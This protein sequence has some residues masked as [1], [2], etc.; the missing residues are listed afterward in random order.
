MKLLLVLETDWVSRGPAQH[1]H[2]L[3][4][5]QDRGH[6]VKVIDFDILWPAK[7]WKWPWAKR[8]RIFA[9][10]KAIG[11]NPMEVIRPSMIRAPLLCYASFIPSFIVETIRQIRLFKPDV[12]LGQGVL[13]VFL[14]TRIAK[15]F[16]IPFVRYLLDSGHTLIPESY[17]RPLGSW[18]ETQGLKQSDEVLV[19]NEQLGEYAT[20]M[21]ATTAPK[22]VTAGIDQSRFNRG[23]DGMM[24]R[25]RL[26]FAED[27]TVLF[28]MGWLYD[29][30]GLR[31]LAKAMINLTDTKMRLLILGR[32]DLYDELKELARQ[33]SEKD[34][35]V[36][37]DW[38]QYNEVP[39]Y[40][41]AADICLLPALLNKTMQDI[42]PIKLY[43]YLACGKPVIASRLPGVM[44][45]FGNHSGLIYIKNPEDVIDT[46]KTIRR[47][48]EEYM[49]LRE[50]SLAFVEKLDWES[51]TDRFE[52]I[53]K[54]LIVDAI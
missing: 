46:A 50:Q 49:Q 18:L 4:R 9:D 47:N 10:G 37:L 25:K 27:E 8:E 53:L 16:G 24:I 42:V 5:L 40:V 44:R 14:A 6:D 2:L 3:E 31:E 33:T 30:S 19:I 11:R 36:L 41:A 54:D 43:E 20:R 32:G 17:L 29:F 45:E 51:I 35:I 12:I 52:N 21:G 34:A 48:T 22:V 38:V 13:N 15:M 28:F 23:V 1:H 26:N 7:C 39:Q